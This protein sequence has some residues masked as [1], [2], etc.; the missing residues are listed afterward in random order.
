MTDKKDFGNALIESNIGHDCIQI[1]LHRSCLE[2]HKDDKS[3]EDR[4]I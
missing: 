4:K 3:N 1:E 2:D